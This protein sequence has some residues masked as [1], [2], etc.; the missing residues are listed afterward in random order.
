MT[1]AGGVFGAG[2]RSFESCLGHQTYGA[3]HP[4]R[5]FWLFAWSLDAVSMGELSVHHRRKNIDLLDLHWIH[6]EWARIEDDEIRV[7]ADRQRSD[8]ARPPD[9]GD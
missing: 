2:S 3:P 9:R 1:G 7:L 6:L 4:R 5:V 8:L